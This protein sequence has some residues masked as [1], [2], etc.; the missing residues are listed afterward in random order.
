M[1]RYSL[2][3][4]NTIMNMHDVVIM[5]TLKIV[6]YLLQIALKLMWKLFPTG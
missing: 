3:Q 5:A 4:Y 1:C 2:I 6:N